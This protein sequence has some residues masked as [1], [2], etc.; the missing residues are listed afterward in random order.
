MYDCHTHEGV[1]V[2]AQPPLLTFSPSNPP[3]LL[4]AA[5][6]PWRLFQH[7][8]E[9][10]MA[11]YAALWEAAESA[12]PRLGPVVPHDQKLERESQA[13]QQFEQ[14]KARLRRFPRSREQREVWRQ[15]LLNAA[16]EL[17]GGSFGQLVQRGG[18]RTIQ[19]EA[20]IEF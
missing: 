20:R 16:R 9:G 11:K 7:K 12:T 4:E 17:A 3:P 6:E 8:V 13:N 15:E 2:V 19:L 10:Y 18:G 14:I 5:N 1:K